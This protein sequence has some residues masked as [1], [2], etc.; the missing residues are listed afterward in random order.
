MT[1]YV[2]TV[3]NGFR[4]ICEAADCARPMC[5]AVYTLLHAENLRAKHDREYHPAPPPVES[6]DEFTVEGHVLPVSVNLN[7]AAHC[8]IEAWD[9][10]LG[11]PGHPHHLAAYAG[12]ERL[13]WDLTG[14]HD[15]SEAALALA[16]AILAAP[17]DLLAYV[18][19]L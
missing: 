5:V 16:R 11:N 6:E 3:G 19:P 1:A 10:V 18:P 15:D 2:E 12:M 4:V 14:T 9:A 17:T 8:L 13:W 7:A